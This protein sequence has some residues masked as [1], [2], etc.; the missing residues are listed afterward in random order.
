[1]DVPLTWTNA[2]AITLLEA[3]VAEDGPLETT[4]VGLFVDT[5]AQPN[6]DSVLGDFTVPTYTGYA[7]EAVTW[8]P[9]TLADD[10]AYEIIGTAGEFRAADNLGS[11]LPVYGTTFYSGS[12]LHAAG[13]FEDGPHPMGRTIDAQTVTVRLR[14]VGGGLA[15]SLS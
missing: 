1:M 12:A 3:A 11:Q 6:A 7:G 5:D 13:L 9:L 2:V 14:L 8:G 10:G 15:V 4:T